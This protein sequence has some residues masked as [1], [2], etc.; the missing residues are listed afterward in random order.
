MG[1]LGWERYGCERLRTPGRSPEHR[2]GQ[3]SPGSLAG[4]PAIALVT[5]TPSPISAELKAGILCYKITNPPSGNG[6]HLLLHSEA[7]AGGL[8][9]PNSFPQ[10]WVNERGF[11]SKHNAK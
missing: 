1:C 3:T 6:S 10:D 7:E 9:E 5:T 8:P 2:E 11:I 4:D